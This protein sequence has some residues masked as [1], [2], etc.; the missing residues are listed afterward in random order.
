M[1][2]KI[3]S[4]YDKVNEHYLSEFTRIAN[5]DGAYIRSILPEALRRFPLR[6]MEARL[7]CDYDS[8]SLFSPEL[9]LKPIAWSIYAFPEDAADNL[10]SV[11]M[12][13][14]EVQQK[15]DSINDNSEVSNE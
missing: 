8:V 2:E 10:A 9:I 12:T 4:V 1:S 3:Y 7:I 6:D 14:S 15:F 13:S 11:G 5:S